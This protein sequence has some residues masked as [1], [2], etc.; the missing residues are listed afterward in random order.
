LVRILRSLGFD[1]RHS[2]Y[3]GN[4]DRGHANPDAQTINPRIRMICRIAL[5]LV[6]VAVLLAEPSMPTVERTLMA[7]M[8]Q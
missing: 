2:G 6:D 1:L 8:V 3:A 7:R 4:D 5:L